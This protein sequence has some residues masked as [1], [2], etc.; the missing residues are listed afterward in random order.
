M[1]AWAAAKPRVCFEFQVEKI[2]GIS[3]DGNYQVQWAPAWVSRFH[4]I[5]CE[6]LIQ[7][8]LQEQLQREV[9]GAQQAGFR[10][11]AT[12]ES[13]SVPI[14]RKED[15]PED[16]SNVLLAMHELSSRKEIVDSNIAPNSD[17]ATILSAEGPAESSSGSPPKEDTMDSTIIKRGSD[18]INSLRSLDS[19]ACVTAVEGH[20]SE[21][22]AQRRYIVE[23]EPQFLT[24]DLLK[25]SHM[26]IDISNQQELSELMTSTLCADTSDDPNNAPVSINVN[27]EEDVSGSSQTICNTIVSSSDAISNN[28]EGNEENY[29]F[30]SDLARLNSSS[31][32]SAKK[33][34]SNSSKALAKRVQLSNKESKKRFPCYHCGKSYEETKA[35]IKHI[36]SPCEWLI[37]LWIL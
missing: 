26:S 34:E 9:N 14:Q 12:E 15:D 13:E 18:S 7:E 10:N 27:N 16:N 2:I 22:C 17:P 35:L 30:L 21:I 33:G 20:D 3:T 36:N 6:H 28:D 1:D 31:K 37:F 19:V 11:N 32:T 5:G 25:P 8:F 29:R 4:L 23:E 24:S